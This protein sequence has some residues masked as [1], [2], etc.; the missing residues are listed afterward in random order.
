MITANVAGI[1]GGDRKGCG[2]SSS[3]SSDELQ[4]MENQLKFEEAESSSK[5][6][7]TNQMICQQDG[8]D[9]RTA[10]ER[11]QAHENK[12]NQLRTL[13]EEHRRKKCWKDYKSYAVFLCMGSVIIA[14]IVL[15]IMA[16]MG[17]IFTD[18]DR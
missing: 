5:K 6:A 2:D 4:E 13:I 1:L 18:R 7:V 12:V 17:I 11:Q 16:A 15:I 14:A 9:P 10:E 8:D 3:L